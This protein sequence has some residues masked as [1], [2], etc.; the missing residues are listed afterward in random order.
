M[1]EPTV[2]VKCVHIQAP[3]HDEQFVP[4]CTVPTCLDFVT[5]EKQ[6]LLCE[7]KNPIGYCRDFKEVP[8]SS[9]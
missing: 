4:Y 9:E 7:V 6:L 1:K 2:C 8:C 3:L 5:G